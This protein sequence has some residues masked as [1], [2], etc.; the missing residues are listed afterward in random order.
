[1]KLGDDLYSTAGA[2]KYNIIP[3]DVKMAQTVQ[4]YSDVIPERQ[5]DNDAVDETLTR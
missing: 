3:S 2:A 4:L 1:L 5:G